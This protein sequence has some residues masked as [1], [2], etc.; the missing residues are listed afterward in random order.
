M[1][2]IVEFTS[3]VATNGMMFMDTEFVMKLKDVVM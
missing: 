3:Y 2:L 1:E